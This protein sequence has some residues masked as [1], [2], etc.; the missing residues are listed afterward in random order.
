MLRMTVELRKREDYNMA[1]TKDIPRFQ[2]DT[3]Y[4]LPYLDATVPSLKLRTYPRLYSC[5]FRNA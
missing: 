3:H 4:T 5:F 1:S 2:Y